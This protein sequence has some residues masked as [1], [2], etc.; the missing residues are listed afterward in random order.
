MS[1][2]CSVDCS[3]AAVEKSVMLRLYYLAQLR[4]VYTRAR[5][6][7]RAPLDLRK[8]LAAHHSDNA[9]FLSDRVGDLLF[10][11]VH[12]RPVQPPVP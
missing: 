9:C 8:H 4:L 7:A 1:L 2:H 12:G 6:G 11:L 10:Q 5:R 3:S